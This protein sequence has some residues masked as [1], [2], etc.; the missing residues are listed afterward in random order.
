MVRRNEL[1]S[2]FKS[3]DLKEIIRNAVL[4]A[5]KE[6]S[7]GLKDAINEIVAIA[8]EPLVAKIQVLEG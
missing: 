3:N 5:I 4:E 2:F 7:R 6:D 1:Q 8:N